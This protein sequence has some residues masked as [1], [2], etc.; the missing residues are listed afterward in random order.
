MFFAKLFFLMVICGS[1]V[2]GLSALLGGNLHK[3]GESAIPDRLVGG[4]TESEDRAPELMED[5]KQNVSEAL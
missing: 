4:E 2:L 5:T 3:A 1:L